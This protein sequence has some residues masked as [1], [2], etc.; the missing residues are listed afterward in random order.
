[1]SN[2]YNENFISVDRGGTRFNP[3]I[4]RHLHT[5]NELTTISL[6]NLTTTNLMTDDSGRDIIV[7]NDGQLV[8]HEDIS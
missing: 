1:M 8:Y 5:Q 2:H 7:M 3:G 6:L 4:S